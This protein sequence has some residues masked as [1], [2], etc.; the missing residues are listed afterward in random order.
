VRSEGASADQ[1][2]REFAEILG[3]KGHAVDNARLA[4]ERLE[5]AFR[6]GALQRTPELTQSLADLDFALAQAEGEKL[7]GKSAEA[8]RFIGRRIVRLLEDA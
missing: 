7:G 1:A 2:R 5:E 8:A 6:N 4:I 3:Q